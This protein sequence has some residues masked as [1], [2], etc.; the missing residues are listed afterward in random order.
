MFNKQKFSH[1]Q[2]NDQ[3]L[4]DLVEE[5]FEE[6]SDEESAKIQGGF[7]YNPCIDLNSIY[8][9]STPAFSGYPTY[10]STTYP[11]ESNSDFEARMQESD[12]RHQQHIDLIWGD[13]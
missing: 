1:Q 6:L 11:T 5:Q 4:T 8:W 13:Y 3:K 10:P 12:R 2:P 9:P 7:F